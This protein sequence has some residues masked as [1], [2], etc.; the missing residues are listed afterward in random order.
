[1]KTYKRTIYWVNTKKSCG[2]IAVDQDGNVYKYD[3]APCYKWMAGKKFS[4]MLEYMKYKKYLLNC[5]KIG[6]DID[7]F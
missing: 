3:T 7:P 2:A 5:K 4:K 1:M 6:I